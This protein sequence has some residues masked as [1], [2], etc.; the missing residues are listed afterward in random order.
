[1]RR[2]LA[3]SLAVAGLSV[4]L[5]GAVLPFQ[6]PSGELAVTVTYTGKG[7]VDATHEILV[8]LFDHP[9]PT[10]ESGPPIGLQA[11][12]K[13]GGTATFKG[14][15]PTPVY[16]TLVYDE[17][18]DYDGKSGPPPAGT[19]I[20]SYAKAGKPIAV[21]PAAGVKVKATFDDSR[22]WGK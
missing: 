2:L 17:Q 8:F 12:T 13:S 1:M 5:S 18:A 21:K 3:S 14:L 19:P 6:T 7:K 4:A 10:G 9:S 11:I 15:G 20:G 16:I 22:R